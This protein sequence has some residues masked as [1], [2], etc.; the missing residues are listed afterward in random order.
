[1]GIIIYPSVYQSWSD[2]NTCTS[3]EVIS[4]GDIRLCGT[5]LNRICLLIGND[6]FIRLQLEKLIKKIREVYRG[7]LT[8]A[9]E[10]IN[11]KNI[12][13]WD[14]LDYI[15]IDAYFALTDKIN[16]YLK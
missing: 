6:S 13:F 8:Y 7:K 1:M 15:G 16:P 3:I 5:C 14:A 10:G 9:A 12:E 4:L 11:A 2:L